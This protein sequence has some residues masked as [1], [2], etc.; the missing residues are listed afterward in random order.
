MQIKKTENN[1]YITLYNI[2]FIPLSKNKMTYQFEAIADENNFEEFCKDLLNF[3]YSTDSFV[4][5]K[6]KGSFQNGIDI[7]SSELKIAVQCKKKKLQRS[8][9]TIENELIEDFNQSINLTKQF[10]H[11]FDKFI[12]L[13]TSKKY[14]RVQDYALELSKLNSFEVIFWSWED[15]EP[16]IRDSEN[17]RKKYYAHLYSPELSY[18]RILTYL[19]KIDP[20]D[21]IGRNNEID[22]LNKKLN[23]SNKTVVLN[24]IGGIGKSSL[25]KLFVYN[26][27]KLYDHI[28][29]ID[30]HGMNEINIGE[31]VS[32]SEIFTNNILLQENINVFFREESSNEDKLL[33]ILNKIQN[34][35]GNN[36]MVIDGVTKE[37]SNYDDMMPGKPNWQVLLTSRD[38]I[39]DYEIVSLDV[40][41][42]HFAEELF[43][44]YYL[45]KKSEKLKDLLNLIGNHTLTIELFAKTANKRNLSIDDLMISLNNEGLNISKVAKV[46]VGHE[47]NK[48][49]INP[50]YYLCSIFSIAKLSE[51]EIKLLMY[52]SVFPAIQFSYSELKLLFQ[53]PDNDNIFFECLSELESKGWVK[54]ENNNY[55]MH[56]I[57]QTVLR[58]KLKPSF[59]NC[60]HLISTLINLLTIEFEENPLNV[61]KYVLIAENIAEFIEDVNSD[62][63][64]SFLIL[65]G[66]REG[67]LSNFAKDL[68]YQNRALVLLEKNP[69]KN[70]L[71]LST[72]YNNLQ[73]V[74][75]TLGDIDKALKFQ[76]DSIK[77]QEKI[78]EPLHPDLG[79]SYNNLSLIYQI[80]GKIDCAFDY[81]QRAIL[82]AENTLEGNHPHLANVFNNF[83]LLLYEYDNLEEAISYQEKSFEIRKKILDEEH[84]QIA[85]GYGNLGMMYFAD[86]QKEKGKEF[87][88]KSIELKKVIYSDSHY[89]LGTAYNNL[90]SIYL[91]QNNFLKAEETQKMAINIEENSLGINHY[92]LATTYSTMAI[93]QLKLDNKKEAI[94]NVLRSISIT[95]YNFPNGHKDLEIYNTFLRHISNL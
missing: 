85:E 37:F 12:L 93:I 20:N 92:T 71:Q 13:S 1:S 25:A 89:S 24:G 42:F 59:S 40:L 68:Y 83:S 17:L 53:I 77:I 16:Y 60:S 63:I 67:D 15:L 23:I 95:E 31:L 56:Q 43:Y 28:L 52:F 58:D 33:I 66:L 57:I 2:V 14:G 44:K 94:R 64:I 48:T 36:L 75:K 50:F 41:D 18:P 72:C 82:I 7:F 32:F 79:T 3:K 90:S 46:Y 34:I 47:S 35:P 45:L 88:K 86:G 74:Y 10:K 8:D 91:D 69:S 61:T 84:P 70:L 51:E 81:Q 73:Y 62:T 9:K 65:L 26:Y 49:L 5:Y 6:T 76:L 54:N 55:W 30:A 27:N 22:N 38:R 11:Q 78:L 4:K 19:P 80:L 21:M 87:L 29:W 39:S